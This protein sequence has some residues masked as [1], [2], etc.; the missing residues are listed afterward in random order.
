[1]LLRNMAAFCGNSH[2]LLEE[3]SL[4]GIAGDGQRCSEMLIRGFA[5]TAAKLEIAQRGE[6]KR[7]GGQ[8]I[9]PGNG[10]NLF[11]PTFG[12]FVLRDRDGAVEGDDRRRA[13]RH[14]RVVE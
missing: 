2:A 9:R 12:T 13:N 6:V 8:S 14:Q 11:E 7:I 1:M 5:S 10:V 4:H 3:P